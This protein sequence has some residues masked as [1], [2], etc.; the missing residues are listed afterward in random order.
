MADPTPIAVV[1]QN[2]FASA[3][4]QIVYDYR[5]S[6]NAGGPIVQGN[7]VYLRGDPTDPPETRGWGLVNADAPAHAD[8]NIYGLDPDQLRGVALNA[9]VTGQPIAVCTADT[10]FA[11]GGAITKGTTYYAFDDGEFAIY[12][13]AANRAFCVVGVAIST[14]NMVLNLSAGGS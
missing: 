11:S 4:A 2:V 12:N 14:S 8:L 7:I 6:G 3:A 10:N 1:R 9:G 5:V 13:S